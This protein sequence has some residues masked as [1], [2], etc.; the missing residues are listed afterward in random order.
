MYAT[1]HV[2]IVAEEV[3]LNLA[4]MS[5]KFFEIYISCKLSTFSFSR[6]DFFVF[7]VEICVHTIEFANTFKRYNR[8][9]IAK[10]K[11]VTKQIKIGHTSPRLS[12]FQG[13]M[14]FVFIFYLSLLNKSLSL[15]YLIR[16]KT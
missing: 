7:A 9:E 10:Q 4:R 8:H 6:N 1:G 11:N 13:R 2:I 5:V 15:L 16:I 14:R 12:N 3:T